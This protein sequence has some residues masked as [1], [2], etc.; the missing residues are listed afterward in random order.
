MSVARAV[1]ESAEKMRSPG[2]VTGCRVEKAANGGYSV[3]NEHEHYMENNK[4]FVYTTH[5]EVAKH[6]KKHLK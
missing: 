6:L 4:P 1:T 2:K 5:E 3:K